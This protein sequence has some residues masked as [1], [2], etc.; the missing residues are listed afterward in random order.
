MTAIELKEHIFQFCKANYNEENVVKY[1]HY[2]KRDYNAWGLTS[3]QIRAKVKEILRTKQINLDVVV[4]A[5]PLIIKNG[6]HEEVM[7]ALLLIE[8]FSKKYTR[9]TFY[10]ISYWFSISIDNWALADVTG[11]FILSYFLKQ[12]VL[13][14]ADFIP[15]I[16]SPYKFQRRCVPVAFIKLLKTTNDF[17]LLFKIIEPLMADPER[18]VHQG[19]GWF[20]RE[21]WKIKKVETEKFLLKWKEKSPRLI[22]QYACEKM[23]KEEKSQFKKIK[24]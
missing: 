24:K 5:T 11:M 19:T 7:I 14:P 10:E 22:I 17:S 3:P 8:A 9:E 16:T 23:T 13:V 15:W 12:S 20:L 21:A 6:K 1:S 18:E 2:F 4:E